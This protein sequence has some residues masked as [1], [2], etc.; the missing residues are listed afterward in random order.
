MGGT[1][2]LQDGQSDRIYNTSKVL[3][4]KMLKLLAMLAL[5]SV[6]ENLFLTSVAGSS[7]EDVIKDIISR[8]NDT[9]SYLPAEDFDAYVGGRTGEY[10]TFSR[11]AASIIGVMYYICK[12]ACAALVVF[13]CPDH[14][15][16]IQCEL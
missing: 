5:I 14:A 2:F 1:N 10:A 4:I 8:D 13:S 3:A 9:T 12:C 16:C 7:T 15:L 11:S 6:A